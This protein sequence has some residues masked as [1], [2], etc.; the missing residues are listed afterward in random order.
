MKRIVPYLVIAL[1]AGSIVTAQPLIVYSRDDF[2]ITAGNHKVFTYG[3]PFRIRDCPPSPVHT[4]ASQ[5]RLRLVGNFAV[6]FFCGV[7]LIRLFRVTRAHGMQ[8][9]A[10]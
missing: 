1:I 6:F 7:F 4:S 9:E 10:A 8:P 5:V 2:T 3:F